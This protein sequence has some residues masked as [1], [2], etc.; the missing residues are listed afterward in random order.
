MTTAVGLGIIAV[1]SNLIMGNVP[2]S[3]GIY[4]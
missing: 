3:F 1:V 2:G 4:G